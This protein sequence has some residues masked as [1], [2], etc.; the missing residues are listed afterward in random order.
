[1]CICIYIYI[2]RERF[3]YIYIY[4]YIMRTGRAPVRLGGGLGA[5]LVEHRAAQNLPPP[6]IPFG[7]H[8]SKL[9]RHRED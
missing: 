8:S 3:V 5:R 4:I 2:E 1:M 6:W 9:E 7:D